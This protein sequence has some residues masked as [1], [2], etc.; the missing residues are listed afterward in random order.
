MQKQYCQQKNDNKISVPQSHN[1][2]DHFLQLTAIW[3]ELNWPVFI[4]IT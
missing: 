2:G 1:D 4:I 3:A